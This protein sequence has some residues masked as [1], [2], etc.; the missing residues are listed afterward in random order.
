MEKKKRFE[1]P[2]AIA[3]EFNDDDIILTSGF[4]DEEDPYK[5]WTN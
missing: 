3:I 1:Y 5:Q 4:G 2:E